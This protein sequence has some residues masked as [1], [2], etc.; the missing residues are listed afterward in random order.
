LLHAAGN[1]VI[2][3][4]AGT[5]LNTQL[6]TRILPELNSADSDDSTTIGVPSISIKEI[7]V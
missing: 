4:W 7:V 2:A 3:A 1:V 5:W 6:R